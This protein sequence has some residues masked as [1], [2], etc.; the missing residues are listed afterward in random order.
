MIQILVISTE[1]ERLDD[2]KAALVAKDAQVKWSESCKSALLL[3]KEEKFDLVI[4]DETISDNHGLDCIRKLIS[5][6]PFQN[7]VAISA[8][9]PDEFH[10][11][12]EGLGILMQ[13]SP[14]SGEEDV[15]KMLTQLQWIKESIIK[16]KRK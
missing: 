15:E 3:I 2:L 5:A 12:S 1:N 4:T 6:N 8:L 16:E 9:S 11:Q 14:M 10:E 13:L 7:C